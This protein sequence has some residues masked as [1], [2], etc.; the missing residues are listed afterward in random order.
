MLSHLNEAVLPVYVLHQ[1]ILLLAAYC[2]FP[3]GLPVP[4]EAAVLVAITGLG[5]LAIYEVAIRPFGVSRFL[6][7]VK[8]KGVAPRREVAAGAASPS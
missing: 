5:S 1:P 2:V 3:L 4:V 6:F 8:A 7:G